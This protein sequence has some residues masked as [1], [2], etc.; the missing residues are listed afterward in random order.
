MRQTR[1]VLGGLHSAS[2]LMTSGGVLPLYAPIAHAGP[3]HYCVILRDR[4]GGGQEFFNTCSDTVTVVWCDGVCSRYNNMVNIA[5]RGT[6][7]VSDDT[8]EYDVCAGRDSAHVNGKR[9]TCD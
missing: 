5:G 2:L 8:V 9:V 4:N 6:F 3:A 7:S 1:S